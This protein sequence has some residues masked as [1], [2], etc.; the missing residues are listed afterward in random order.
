MDDAETAE[1]NGYEKSAGPVW[2]IVGGL[3]GIVVAMSLFWFLLS[4]H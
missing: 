3:I 4:H 1:D 2:G